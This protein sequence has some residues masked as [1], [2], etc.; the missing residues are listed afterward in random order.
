MHRGCCGTYCSSHRSKTLAVASPTC[1]DS[2]GNEEQLIYS[3][4]QP[5]ACQTRLR[6]ARQHTCAPSRNPAVTKLIP[7]PSNLLNRWFSAPVNVHRSTS[8]AKRGINPSL[9]EACV[10][11]L[12]L[13]LLVC[14]RQTVV[15]GLDLTCKWPSWACG[16]RSAC[17]GQIVLLWW[18]LAV[19]LLWLLTACCWIGQ[20]C[21]ISITS[22]VCLEE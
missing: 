10:Y 11:S 13:W 9:V 12:R 1:W 2:N 22:V 6:L 21:R 15:W 16:H 17:V 5:I 18:G 7:S 14:L 3:S 19:L 4:H 20:S 8:V